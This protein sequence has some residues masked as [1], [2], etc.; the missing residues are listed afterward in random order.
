MTA[1]KQQ[2]ISAIFN[3]F[4][5][6]KMVI[7]FSDSRASTSVGERP[8]ILLATPGS[9]A[10]RAAFRNKSSKPVKL[11]CVAKEVAVSSSSSGV[12]FL[13]GLSTLPHILSVRQFDLK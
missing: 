9:R 10:Q 8:D 7:F 3:C 2:V 4:G 11:K 1:P 6:P 12:Y 13:N 5:C